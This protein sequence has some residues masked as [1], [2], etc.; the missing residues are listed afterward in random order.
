MIINLCLL[1]IKGLLTL[2]LAPLRLI[3]FPSSVATVFAR[4]ITVLTEGADFCG[5]FMH[6]QYIGALLAFVISVAAFMNGYRLV[7]WILRKIP[8]LNID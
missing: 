3:T 5:A 8:F 6:T 1:L 4:I 2:F 7:M